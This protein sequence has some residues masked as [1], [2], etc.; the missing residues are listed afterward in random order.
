MIDKLPMDNLYKFMVILGIIMMT[1]PF[2]L[3][4]TIQK[5]DIKLLDIKYKINEHN[6]Q[7]RELE[8][9]AR[10]ML[11]EFK[12]LKTD[13]ISINNK[14]K[15]MEE[16]IEN[17]IEK[18]YEVDGIK[19]DIL[20]IKKS[21]EN[22]KELRKRFEGVKEKNEVISLEEKKFLLSANEIE[23]LLTFEKKELEEYIIETRYISKIKIISFVFPWVGFFISIGGGLLWY[24][25][26]Q[27]YLDVMIKKESQRTE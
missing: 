26:T 6:T 14:I 25:K 17:S 8:E 2:T 7:V 19:K 4:P 3:Y 20:G 12:N 15:T 10:K 22:I 5:Y 11:N 1:L 16:A 9:K 27:K 18:R 23:N 24:F 21:T 13:E